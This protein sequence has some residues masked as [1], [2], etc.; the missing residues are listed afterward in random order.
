MRDV[1]VRMEGG[2]G[3]VGFLWVLEGGGGYTFWMARMC[4]DELIHR[5]A[6]C[7]RRLW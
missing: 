3:K 5:D 2:C 6:V 1:A 4:N 7:F